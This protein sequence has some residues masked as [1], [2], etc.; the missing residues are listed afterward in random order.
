MYIDKNV[1]EN[2]I[3]LLTF[4]NVNVKSINRYGAC[5]DMSFHSE[6][7][8]IFSNVVRFK[9]RLCMLVRVDAR[10]I[11]LYWDYVWAGELFM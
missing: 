9:D 11:V 2:T 5:K 8:S 6:L 3:T 4:Q 1:N 10:V 7:R